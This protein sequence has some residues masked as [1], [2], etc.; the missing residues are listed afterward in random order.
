MPY[1]V[2]VDDEQMDSIAQKFDDHYTVV[3][4]TNVKLFDQLQVLRNGA[5]QGP[6]ADAFTKKM[7][8]DLMPGLSNLAQ[9]LLQAGEVTREVKRIIKEAD[10][11]NKSYF[12]T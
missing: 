8:E 1:T 9:A 7:N 11:Q 5:W 3:E 10:D 12:P 6:N 2:Q 4:Q